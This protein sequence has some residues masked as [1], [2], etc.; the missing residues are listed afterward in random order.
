MN[1]EE[2]VEHYQEIYGKDINFTFYGNHT[3]CIH[4]EN[5]IIIKNVIN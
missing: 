5:E 1:K 4:L 2:I 3:I